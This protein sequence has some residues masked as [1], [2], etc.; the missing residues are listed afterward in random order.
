MWDKLETLYEQLFT[1]Y[2]YMISSSIMKI[3]IKNRLMIC[4]LLENRLIEKIH[5][6]L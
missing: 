2:S 1:F 6:Q 4:F 5:K 3:I